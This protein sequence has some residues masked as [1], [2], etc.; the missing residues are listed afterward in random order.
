MIVEC[1]F[2]KL[3]DIDKILTYCRVDKNLSQWVE[4]TTTLMGSKKDYPD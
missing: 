1:S 2:T 4:E 3:S